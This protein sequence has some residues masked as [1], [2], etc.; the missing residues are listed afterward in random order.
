MAALSNGSVSVRVS[1][2]V[3]TLV[4]VMNLVIMTVTTAGCV[5]RISIS[6]ADID[7]NGSRM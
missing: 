1:V 2:P 3:I 4:V 5:E 6:S 7:T